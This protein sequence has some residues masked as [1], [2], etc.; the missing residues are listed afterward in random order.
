MSDLE[1]ASEYLGEI[2]EKASG[3]AEEVK[4]I[5]ENSNKAR[6]GEL[7]PGEAER[8]RDIHGKAIDF[9]FSK[10]TGVGYGMGGSALG[11]EIGLYDFWEAAE[12][13]RGIEGWQK[14]FS[15][16]DGTLTMSAV[17]AASVAGGYGAS[18]LALKKADEV[19][20]R[21]ERNGSDSK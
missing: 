10:Y 14:P 9:C 2:R 3:G 11:E 18:Y 4:W 20:S 21:S 15:N 16:D 12:G 1:S 13:Y 19:I 5:L 8:F 17:A 6:K 7:D